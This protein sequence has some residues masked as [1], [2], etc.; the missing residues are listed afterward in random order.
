MKKSNVLLIGTFATFLLHLM[1]AAR[2][3]SGTYKTL[4]DDAWMADFT[5]VTLAPAK[6]I[7]VKDI[8]D[9]KVYSAAEAKWG[10]HKNHQESFSSQRVGDT[11]RIWASEQG[12]HKTLRLF[13]DSTVQVK[14]SSSNLTFD[15][16]KGGATAAV[17]AV[18]DKS[19]FSLRTFDHDSVHLDVLHINA[20]NNSTVNLHKGSVGTVS[21]NLNNSRLISEKASVQQMQV[22]ADDASQVQISSK[23]LRLIQNQQ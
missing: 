13:I 1:V 5:W 6:V 11:V 21:I 9:V 3:K 16:A 22:Q 20:A 14:A 19:T 15:G 4:S 8:S 2:F 18:L 7:E 23:Q 10:Y 12:G 17:H